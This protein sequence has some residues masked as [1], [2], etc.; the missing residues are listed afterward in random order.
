MTVHQP[1]AR[2]YLPSSAVLLTF[3]LLPGL[4]SA[5]DCVTAVA[6]RAV[7]APTK[8]RPVVRPPVRRPPPSTEVGAL[9]TPK[10][11]PVAQDKPQQPARPRVV[12]HRKRPPASAK[13]V[14][15]EQ[16]P[17]PVTKAV[18]TCTPVADPLAEVRSPLKDAPRF[19]PIDP[20]T[21]LLIVPNVVQEPLEGI[22]T[23]LP[24]EGLAPP[25]QVALVPP[26]IGGGGGGGG[27]G[28]QLPAVEKP[29]P[30][31]NPNPPVVIIPPLVIVPPELIDPP[32]TD[33]PIDPG[34]PPD[35]DGTHPVPVPG[36]VW[37]VLAGL[38]GLLRQR[39]RVMPRAQRSL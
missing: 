18:P 10:A 1:V 13:L 26:S 34:T 4:V 15:S 6:P 17:K 12:I 32:V 5:D 2:F 8:P 23:G 27:G 35:P 37:L 30:P 3:A 24:G 29:A 38:T 14:A 9:A 20:P 11:Q 19:T 7:T 31:L 28:S 22:R 21:R 33:K 36:S 25:F 39:W 16:A